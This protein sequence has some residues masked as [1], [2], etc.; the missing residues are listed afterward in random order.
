M[1]KFLKTKVSMI[2]AGMMVISS[3][4][5]FADAKPML[6]SAPIAVSNEAV[7]LTNP[8]PELYESGKVAFEVKQAGDAF[9]ITLEENP[10]TGYAWT[11]GLSKASHV[12]FISENYYA[13]NLEMPGAPGK[14]TYT[15][16]VLDEG[17][18]TINFIYSRPWDSTGSDEL[19]ILVYKN[20]EKVFVEEDQIVTIQEG[21]QSDDNLMIQPIKDNEKVQVENQE[22]IQDGAI[23]IDMSEAKIFYNN[24]EISNDHSLKIIDGKT[25]VPLASVLKVLD[26]KITWNAETRSVDVQKGPQWTSVKIGQNA[27]FKNK[28]APEPLSSAP[29]IVEGY[30]YVPA[31]FLVEILGLGIQIES[32]SLKI[33]D[34]ESAIHSGFITNID[35]DVTGGQTITIAQNK[36]EKDFAKTVVIHTSKAYTYYNTDIEV[37]NFV[38]VVS[39]MMMTMSLPPQTSGY[40]IY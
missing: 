7:L 30:T 31:E 36:D 9:T 18:S 34:F 28:M 38:R 21:S 4:S 22:Q 6:I 40:I 33:T 2:L 11:Y 5:A 13:S 26:Y 20:G 17:V 27:Y 39:P 8:V 3:A 25:M 1:R 15:F 12:E 37:G 35:Y 32:G 29:V 24:K 14:K 19:N 23:E 10:S 16:K